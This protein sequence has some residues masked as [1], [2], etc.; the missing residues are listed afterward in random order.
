MTNK[1]IVQLYLSIPAEE[2]ESLTS[3]VKAELKEQK[4]NSVDLVA[5]RHANLMRMLTGINILEKRKDTEHAD[6]RAVIA[7]IMKEE[8]YSYSQIAHGLKKTYAMVYYYIDNMQFYLDHNLVNTMT[9][10]LSKYRKYLD[11]LV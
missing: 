7:Y 11:S 2:R 1:E 3:E 4:K 5:Q 6:A 9:R 8:G 10:L